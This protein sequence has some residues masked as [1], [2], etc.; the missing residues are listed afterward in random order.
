MDYRK[1]LHFIDEQGHHMRHVL[2]EQEFY[3]QLYNLAAFR[4]IKKWAFKHGFFPV[5]SHVDQGT[6][7]V[8]FYYHERLRDSTRHLTDF[9][10]SFYYN[11]LEINNVPRINFI[12]M[13]YTQHIDCTLIAS[14]KNASELERLYLAGMDKYYTDRLL[15][16]KEGWFTRMGWT[17][18]EFERWEQLLDEYFLEYS[19]EDHI[20]AAINEGLIINK[21]EVE[22]KYLKKN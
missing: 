18:E 11:V 22:I 2:C 4:Y 21:T 20:E 9:A 15:S 6:L 7:I 19:E 3:I 14:C 17:R 10:S 16:S 1:T 12:R 13:K 8:K 5:L